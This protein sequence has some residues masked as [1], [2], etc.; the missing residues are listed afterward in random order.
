MKQNGG[1]QEWMLTAIL[2]K[3]NLI[4]MGYNAEN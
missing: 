2:R 1:N 3:M 4:K